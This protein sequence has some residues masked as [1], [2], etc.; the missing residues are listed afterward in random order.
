MADMRLVISL[1]WLCKGTGIKASESAKRACHYQNLTPSI[2]LGLKGRSMNALVRN[3]HREWLTLDQLLRIAG[4]EN[5]DHAHISYDPSVVCQY[6]RR[7]GCSHDGTLIFVRE[8]AQ[9]VLLPLMEGRSF[10]KPEGQPKAMIPRYTVGRIKHVVV[11]GTVDLPIGRYPGQ[12]ERI[13]MPVRVNWIPNASLS[14]PGG[15]RG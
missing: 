2:M 11:F 4:W 12:R 10:F 13:L 5:E 7:E 8:L 9:R 14:I 6:E 3:L 1:G 15:E